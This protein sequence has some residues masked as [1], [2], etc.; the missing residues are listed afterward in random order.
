MRHDGRCHDRRV[1]P[2]EDAVGR[3]CV[4]TNSRNTFSSGDD[5]TADA[6]DDASFDANS[7]NVHKSRL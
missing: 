6:G 3:V 5:A 4:S 1:C 2:L 7:A